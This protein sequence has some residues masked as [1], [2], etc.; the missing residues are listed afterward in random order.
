MRHGAGFVFVVWTITQV[1]N[2]MQSRINRKRFKEYCNLVTNRA[3]VIEFVAITRLSRQIEF[4][5]DHFD[6]L[7]VLIE[8]H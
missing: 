4:V 2:A 7:A 6:Q 3:V 5:I 1:I 8:Q